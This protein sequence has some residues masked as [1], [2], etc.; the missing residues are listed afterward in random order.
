MTFQEK[1]RFRNRLTLNSEEL[2]QCESIFS[3][4]LREQTMRSSGCR[5]MNEAL[6]LELCILICRAFSGA[7][8]KSLSEISN[9]S[10]LLEF[11]KQHYMEELSLT[12]L[13]RRGHCSVSSLCRL[14]RSA[15]GRSPGEYLNTLRLE[16]AAKDLR[17]KTDSISSI[18]FAHGF[19]DS[20]YFS[21][22]FSRY[23]G[24]SPR[25]YRRVCSGRLQE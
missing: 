25:E 20:N 17:E 13:A 9:L 10:R 6:F 24:C 4:M 22:R 3:R 23:F 19:S 15:L 21:V 2:E 1:Y 7:E 8:R 16:R 14:F 12:E 11:M 18:A 5:A